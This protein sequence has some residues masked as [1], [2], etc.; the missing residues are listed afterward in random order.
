[1]LELLLLPLVLRHYS[2]LAIVGGL[3]LVNAALVS[4]RRRPQA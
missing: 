1:M 4:R 3:L 2:D